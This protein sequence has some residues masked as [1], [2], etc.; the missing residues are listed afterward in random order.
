MSSPTTFIVGG[1]AL[2]FGFSVMTTGI[3]LTSVAP[4][5][6]A[7][8]KLDYESGEVTQQLSGGVPANWAA[9]V[10]REED[11]TRRVICAGS[12]R[13]PNYNGTETVMTLSQWVGDNCGAA[14]TG[15]IGRASWEYENENGNPVM[16]TGSFI[17]D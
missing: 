13:G 15:D 7:L 4:R 17:I 6:L 2:L 1:V 10:V 12:G 14:V 11:G 9:Q 3:E 8:D 5:H 16:V